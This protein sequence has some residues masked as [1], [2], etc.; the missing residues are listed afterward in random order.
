MKQPIWQNGGPY[1][2]KCRPCIPMLTSITGLF[3]LRTR[4][5]QRPD[6][7]I[8][9]DMGKTLSEIKAEYPEG[10]FTVRLDGFPDNAAICFGEPD[11]EYIPYFFGTQ[12]GDAEKAMDVYE[13]QLKCAGFVSTAGVLFPEM[14]D[15]MSFDDFFSLIGVEDYEYL[16]DDNAGAGWL[17]FMYHDLE[18][19][20]NTNEVN[21]DG[22]WDFTGEEIVKRTAPASIVDPELSSANQELADE[23]MFD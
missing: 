10:E 23:V 6:A 15:E 1:E 21:A 5:L 14:K 3:C 19:M 17:R 22:G 16:G 12:S 20:V 8:F 4:S 18:V 13:D 7:G 2:T 11:T 9:Q